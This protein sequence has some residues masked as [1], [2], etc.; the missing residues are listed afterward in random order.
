MTPSGKVSADLVDSTDFV[1]TFIELTGGKLPTDKKLDGHSFAPQLLAQTGSPRQSVFIQ[2]ARMWYVR[3]ANWKLN[4]RGE[5]YD[6]SKAPFSETIVPI[7]STNQEA[8]SA[9]TRLTKILG[10]LDP[11]AGIK[12][13]GD[14][15][16]RHANK[17]TDKN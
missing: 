5:L 9:R 7:E 6:M 10:E 12:D 13:T 17:K 14:G 15:T 8:M 2:L 1:P 16:G 11:A 4:E 3:D